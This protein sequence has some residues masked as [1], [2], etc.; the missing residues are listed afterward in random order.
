MGDVAIHNRR[1]GAKLFAAI[2]VTYPAGSTLTCTNGT[3]TLKA[4]T[5]TGQWVFA[6]PKAGTWT[7]TVTDGTNS[8]SQS[9]SITK[10]G[11]FESV[12]LSYAYVIFDEI[13]GL[14]DGVTIGENAEVFTDDIGYCL[15]FANGGGYNNMSYLD[16]GFD[17]T[18]YTTLE[19][20]GYATANRYIGV[21][22]P[23]PTSS[24]QASSDPVP[25]A[26]ITMAKGTT[27]SLYTLDI[28]KLSGV[29]Y[30]ATQYA[31]ADTY[32]YRMALK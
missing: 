20:Y 3:S 21:W 13:N 18:D 27:P 14:A 32:V 17:L 30:I 16:T 25:K 1:G 31:T 9:V 6:I 8:K 15:L 24:L 5:T 19:I 7:V 26:S 28:S 12:E 29:H 4:K 11:Q 22:N 23:K 2:G 10:E